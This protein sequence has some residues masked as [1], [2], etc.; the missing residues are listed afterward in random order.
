[1]NRI[2][3]T[4]QFLHFKNQQSSLDNHQSLARDARGQS[5]QHRQSSPKNHRRQVAWETNTAF[6]GRCPRTQIV[7]FNRASARFAAR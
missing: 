2:C 1:M 4:R 5:S 3:H 7:S 6:G